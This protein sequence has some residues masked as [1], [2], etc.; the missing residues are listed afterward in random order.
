MII[1]KAEYKDIP[2]IINLLS[3]VLEI[4]AKLR[5]DIFVSGT[6]KYNSEYLERM[7][8]DEDF[9][10]DVAVDGDM[11][12]GYAIY[13]VLHPKFDSTMHPIKTLYLDDLCV[14]EKYRCQHVGKALFEQLKVEAR[15]LGCYS[16]NLYAWEGNDAAKKFYEKM[17]MRV[18]ATTM[19]YILK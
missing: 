11:V 8:A 1:R 7:L 5:P 2:Q 6:T 18:R 17:G 15:T 12:L 10:I 4:H 9:V 13:E 3:Q 14:D 19:E 16:I